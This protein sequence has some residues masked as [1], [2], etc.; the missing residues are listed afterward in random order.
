M[1]YRFDVLEPDH[2]NFAEFGMV[3]SKCG[4]HHNQQEE[5]YK[6][7]SKLGCF[8]SETLI[9]FNILEIK[10]RKLELDKL[11]Y[12]I[13]SKE[14]IIPLGDC[15]LLV[16]VAPKGRLDE[17]RIKVFRVDSSKGLVL[18]AGV[19]HFLPFSIKGNADCIIVFKD[20][21]ENNDLTFFP[22][23][24]LYKIAYSERIA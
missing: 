8:E 1:Q 12:H 3:I 15:E 11:E 17:S 23:S 13:N 9:N 10:H 4:R 2:D 7:W 6:W 16:P 22:L 24:R 21:T 14:V 19:Y 20:N 18:N 5:N